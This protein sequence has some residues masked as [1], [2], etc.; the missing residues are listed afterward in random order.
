[1]MIGHV[2]INVVYVWEA[3]AIVAGIPAGVLLYAIRRK[4]RKQIGD[5]SW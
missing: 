1:M 3:F 4:R 2:Y 5:L